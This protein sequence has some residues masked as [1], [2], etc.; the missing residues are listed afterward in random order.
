MFCRLLVLPVAVATLLGLLAAC[1]NPSTNSSQIQVLWYASEPDGTYTEGVTP[2]VISLTRTSTSNEEK[3]SPPLDVEIH[4]P[5][6]ESTGSFW[7][8]TTWEA[9]TVA[10]L[11]ATTDPRG[12]AITYRV[13]ETIDGPSGGAIT[14]LGTLAQ[15]QGSSIPENISLTGT[16][17][18]DGGI[19]PVGGIPQKI[20][21][22]S[23]AG[24]SKLYIPRGQ[25]IVT[26]AESG[27]EV[28]S[29][30]LGTSLGVAV[31][32]ASSIQEVLA[33]VRP[34]SQKPATKPVPP[35]DTAA[36]EYLL[37]AAKK[38]E[39]RAT[40]NALLPAPTKALRV[41]QRRI[42]KSIAEVRD[43]LP[44]L[45]H[46]SAA[47]PAYSM[48]TLSIRTQEEW[49]AIVRAVR[50]VAEKGP[51]P[52]RHELIAK[53]G[54]LQNTISTRLNNLSN[55]PVS[56]LEQLLALPDAL[57]WGIDAK[58]EV[59]TVLATLGTEKHP[60]SSM[61]KEAAGTL[62]EAAFDS[63]QYLPDTVAIATRVG[64]APITNSSDTH[65]FMNSYTAMLTTAARANLSYL[66]QLRNSQPGLARSN[67][68]LDS[69][70]NQL[71]SDLS[72][73]NAANNLDQAAVVQNLA[74][75]TSLFV[76]SLV[77]SNSLETI[78]ANVESAN[79]LSKIS[80]TS[81]EQFSRQQQLSYELTRS[82]AA[83]QAA[84]S[85]DSTYPRL[86]SQW[87]YAIGQASTNLVFSDSLRLESLT[88]MWYSGISALLLT[89]GG[90]TQSPTR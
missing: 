20:Q 1:G 54:Q 32:E 89:T 36:T 64:Q 38:L 84:L 19:G 66:Q 30:E 60:N 73:Q 45:I 35:M 53:A 51:E 14:A 10:V 11:G 29:S 2:V 88:Y 79:Q 21:A 3:S 31:Q 67:P 37:E 70:I 77:A 86:N 62:A 65:S 48:A 81:P 49:N 59:N 33:E 41:E 26:D 85:L 22:A 40:A 47:I 90:H 16:I 42:T 6:D 44:K 72:Q 17:N 18:P 13:D 24:I 43:Q 75:A 55:T 8:A 39:T 28:N 80:I 7:N 87:G 34:E 58:Q 23:Q 74:T 71:N 69:E 57:I 50:S 9:A 52:T 46:N 61:I 76:S 83:Q 25:R 78:A 82:Q 4:T 12:L 15:L 5:N 27:K 63:S 56:K 68:D